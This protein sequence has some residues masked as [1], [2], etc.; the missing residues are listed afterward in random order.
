MA[1]QAI[2]MIIPP[3]DEEGSSKE[4]PD[5]DALLLPLLWDLQVYG[6][7]LSDEQKSALPD[8]SADPSTVGQSCTVPCICAVVFACACRKLHWSILTLVL[9]SVA[10]IFNAW[11]KVFDSSYQ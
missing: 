2:A 8:W 5:L 10:S 4:P 3:D 7:P 11:C 1:Y 6:P 9:N